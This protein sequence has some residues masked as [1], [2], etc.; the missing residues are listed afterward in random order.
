MQPGNIV[1]LP[2]LSSDWIDKDQVILH[3]CFQLL[4]D[5]IEKENLLEVT[6]W[7]QEEYL[8]S[9]KKEIQTLYN[10]WKERIKMYGGNSVDVLH[11]E[12]IY[13]KDDEMLIRLIKVRR[14]LWT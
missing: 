4:C 3:A 12:K 6:D 14:Y 1:H 2:T 8:R 13:D 11:D 5:C 9:A 10:W 7:E